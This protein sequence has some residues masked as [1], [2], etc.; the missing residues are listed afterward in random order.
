MP[1]VLERSLP[2]FILTKVLSIPLLVSKSTSLT[3]AIEGRASPLKPRVLI[4]NKSFSFF[5]LLVACGVK[6]STASLLSIPLPLSITLISFI[7]ASTRLTSILVLPASREFS[8]SSFT[9]LLTFSTTSPAA[10]LLDKFSSIT[11]ISPIITSIS[12]YF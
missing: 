1:S 6:A 8:T 11:F 5:I 9:T 3:L 2:P 12:F 10:I 4:K 7:P